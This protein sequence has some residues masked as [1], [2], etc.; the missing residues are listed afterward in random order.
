[1]ADLTDTDTGI[2]A[3]VLAVAGWVLFSD[4]ISQ[5]TATLSTVE[6]VIV[7]AAIVLFIAMFIRGGEA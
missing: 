4:L 5:W 1:M 6:R 2:V 7:L 3:I